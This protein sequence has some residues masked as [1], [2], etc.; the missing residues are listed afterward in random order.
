MYLLFILNFILFQNVSSID[1]IH[2][3]TI[4]LFKLHKLKFFS[5]F[6]ELYNH[7]H[8]PSQ[9]FFI[10][11]TRKSTYS[12]QSFPSTP[13]SLPWPYTTTDLLF[14]FYLV[15]FDSAGSLLLRVGFL[16]LWQVGATV[17]MVQGLLLR[18]RPVLQTMGSKCAGSGVVA[19]R[20]S[21]SKVRGIFL[22]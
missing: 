19:H 20:L 11:S 10:T 12:Q 18:G 8:N 7:H 17:R 4:Y 14:N 21:C 3:Y 15:I 2:I 16:Q 9:N 6:T 13:N 5:V 22:N 1:I